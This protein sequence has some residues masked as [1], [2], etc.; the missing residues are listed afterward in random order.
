MAKRIMLKKK[1]NII[2]KMKNPMHILTY[3]YKGSLCYKEE[4]ML[5]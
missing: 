1:K 3:I 5:F 2:I 4:K